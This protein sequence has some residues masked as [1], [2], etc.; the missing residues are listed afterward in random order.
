MTKF[1]PPPRT[2]LTEKG[3][4]FSTMT[5]HRLLSLKTIDNMSA[6]A[7]ENLL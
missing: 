3:P 4:R 1:P 5:F 2:K 7:V 6:D